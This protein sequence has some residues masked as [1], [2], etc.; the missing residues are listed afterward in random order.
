MT[1]TQSRIE[2]VCHC[3]RYLVHFRYRIMCTMQFLFTTHWPPK[4]PII[5]KNSMYFDCKQPIKLNIY[6][7]RAIQRSCNHGLIRSTMF[8]RLSQ[9][10]HLKVVL[11]VK[12]D[13][14]GLYYRTHIQ[15]SIWYGFFIADSLIWNL[16]MNINKSIFFSF[17]CITRCRGNS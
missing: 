15:N 17:I 8:V 7:K 3:I 6:S 9:H 12:N 10:H 1:T 14:N 2:F 11:E 4:P 13:S 5:K 16:H